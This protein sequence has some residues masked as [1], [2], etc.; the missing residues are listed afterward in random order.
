MFYTN[1]KEQKP[2]RWSEIDYLAHFQ[3]YVHYSAQAD[4]Y[5]ND[6]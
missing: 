3:I 6:G 4:G 2:I 5:Q 1:K